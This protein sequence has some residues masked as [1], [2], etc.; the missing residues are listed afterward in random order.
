MMYTEVHRQ[1][2]ADILATEVWIREHIQHGTGGPFDGV[3]TSD[4]GVRVLCPVLR[5]LK[6]QRNR[7]DRQLYAPNPFENRAAKI[8]T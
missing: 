2:I 3:P 5:H 1:A 7:L 6:R 8:T 4:P